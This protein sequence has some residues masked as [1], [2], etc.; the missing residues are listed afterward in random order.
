MRYS[1]ISIQTDDNTETCLCLIK[2]F[3][4]VDIWSVGCIMAEMLLGKPLFKG[5][6][7]I[8]PCRKAVVFMYKF[9]RISVIVFLMW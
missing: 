2:C 7:R 9:R 4:S 8:L 3:P 6:D 5:N 1:T